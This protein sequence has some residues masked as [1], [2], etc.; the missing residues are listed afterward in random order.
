MRAPR[1]GVGPRGAVWIESP[2]APPVTANGTLSRAHWS[3]RTRAAKGA[4]GAFGALCNL[5]LRPDPLALG[6]VVVLTRTGGRRVDSDNAAGSLKGARDLV[7]TALGLRDDSA[8]SLRWIVRTAIGSPSLRACVLP[9]HDVTGNVWDVRCGYARATRE[10]TD[11]FG[12]LYTAWICGVPVGGVDAMPERLRPYS[13]SRVQIHAPRGH[14]GPT[15]LMQ[16]D[17]LAALYALPLPVPGD[18][19]WTT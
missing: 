7:A 16:L 8:P 15:W 11:G 1:H 2:G 6:W 18:P 10:P 3:T 5:H 19:T 12:S 4:V 17:T 9:A 14:D 13:L